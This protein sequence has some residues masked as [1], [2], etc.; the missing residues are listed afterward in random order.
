MNI[1]GYD[2]KT[3]NMETFE[4]E[5]PA[6]RTYFV[7]DRSG[8]IWKLVFTAYGGSANGDMTFTQE[9]V[10]AVGIGEQDEAMPLVI[11]PNPV[12]GGQLN[13][14]LD[15]AVRNGRLSVLDVGGR[16][17]QEQLV[18]GDGGFGLL[19]VDVS[20]LGSGLYVIRL[21]AEKTTFSARFVID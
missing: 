18:T 5:Y 4:Y 16:L 8:N 14:V 2:W 11:H 13:I 3:F 20:L 19:P 12:V 9:L 10:S 1:I 21:E 17:V 7:Q 15:R 6:D